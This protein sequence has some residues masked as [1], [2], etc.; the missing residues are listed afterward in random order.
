MQ[1]IGSSKWLANGRWAV[2][3]DCDQV[4]SQWLA[5]GRTEGPQS[6]YEPM[7]A[8]HLGIRGRVRE[9][10]V[11]QFTSIYLLYCGGAGRITGCE[12]LMGTRP[13]VL[14]FE[15]VCRVLILHLFCERLADGR[16]EILGM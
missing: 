13:R 15:E 6:G 9:S 3:R 8:F 7:P 16:V 14:F 11:I 1:F 5:N 10:V 12:E 4:V 2:Q